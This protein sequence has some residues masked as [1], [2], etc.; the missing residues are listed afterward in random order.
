MAHGSDLQEINTTLFYPANATG[1]GE[2]TDRLQ[3][4]A[5]IELVMSC[6]C[7]VIIS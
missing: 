2:E 5:F 7:C 4:N 3:A 6:T 1:I